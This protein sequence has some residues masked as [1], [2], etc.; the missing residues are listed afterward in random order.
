MPRKR[1]PTARERIAL[2]VTYLDDGAPFSAA[3]CLREAADQIEVAGK[4]FNEQLE[5]AIGASDNG[6]LKKP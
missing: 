5:K 1:S 6:K 2:A 4:K 3:R